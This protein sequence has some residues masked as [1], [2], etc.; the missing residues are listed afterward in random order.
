MSNGETIRVCPVCSAPSTSVDELHCKVCGMRFAYVSLYADLAAHDEQMKAINAQRQRIK[1][2]SPMQKSNSVQETGREPSSFAA[3]TLGLEFRNTNRLVIGRH[4]IVRVVLP[5][6]KLHYLI[7]DKSENGLDY[8]S[9]MKHHVICD[10]NGM[11]HTGGSSDWGECILPEGGPFVRCYAVTNVSYW[12]DTKGQVL[13][14]GKR[15][16]QVDAIKQLHNVI[17]LAITE[18]DGK[19]AALHE[20]G[21]IWMEGLSNIS[22][23]ATAIAAGRNFVLYLTRSGHVR[24][25]PETVGGRAWY[26]AEAQA[27]EKAESWRDVVA[28][29]ADQ[30]TMIALTSNGTVHIV[31]MQGNDRFCEATQWQNIVNI[32]AGFGL[33]LG[34]NAQGLGYLAGRHLASNVMRK[35]NTPGFKILME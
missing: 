29:A 28:I 16:S 23:G 17:D 10:E 25:L 30:T 2:Q 22:Q 13:L 35:L 26:T 31:D 32:S 9:D 20:N 27:V 4:D 24:V 5:E 1:D 3:T 34:V 12:I 19:V 14:C 11:P 6:K 21:S 8:S 18:G 33:L 7:A 15:S